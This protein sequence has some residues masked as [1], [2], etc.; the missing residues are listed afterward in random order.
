MRWIR[1]R[2]ET[3]REKN[4]L[5][6]HHLHHQFLKVGFSVSD[7]SKIGTGHRSALETIG[8]GAQI[9]SR[10]LLGSEQNDLSRWL[11]REKDYDQ[12]TC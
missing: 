8:A 3:R 12:I 10:K 11:N 6:L 9:K 1:R 5:Q 2:L 4:K 7:A